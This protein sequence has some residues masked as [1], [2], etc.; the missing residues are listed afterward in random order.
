M[1]SLERW[2]SQ[3]SC[4][5]LASVNEW[6]ILS[7]RI[8][9]SIKVFR[10]GST[11]QRAPPLLRPPS[12]ASVRWPSCRLSSWLS[13]PS[14]SQAVRRCSPLHG[15]AELDIQGVVTPRVTCS[16]GQVT[17]N[18]ACCVLFPLLDDLQTNLFDDGE[19]GEEVSCSE[20]K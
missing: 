11:T 17:A 4:R 8:E 19:C 20:A 1:L 13:P 14:V 5:P 12:S 3:I 2:D 7:G 9:E 15:D 10:N 16:T 18:A 6:F